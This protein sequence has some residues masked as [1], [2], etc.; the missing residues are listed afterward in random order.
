MDEFSSIKKKIGI[1]IVKCQFSFK[2]PLIPGEYSIT[3]DISDTGYG[4]GSFEKNLFFV[5]DAIIF[6][7]IN[8]LKSIRCGGIFNLNPEFCYEVT[9]S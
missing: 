7:V 5:H 3:L 9:N 2:C 4:T 1:D 6:S 8:Y